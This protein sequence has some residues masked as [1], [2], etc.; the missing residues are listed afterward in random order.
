MYQECSL[1]SITGS[2]A[3]SYTGPSLF[4]ANTF[5]DG[6]CITIEGEDVS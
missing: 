1:V 6:T 3:T 5:A 2:S 4:R